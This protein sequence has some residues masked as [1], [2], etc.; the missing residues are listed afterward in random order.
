[1][2]IRTPRGVGAISN[3][4]LDAGEILLER[5]LTFRVV[6]DHGV[7]GGVRRLDVEVVTADE[8][9]A[10]R[11]AAKA[12]AA[13]IAQV[14]GT[15]RLLAD[16]DQL[17]A[18]K[19][20]RAALRQALDPALI[21]AE[22]L[23][24][25]ADRAI[26]DS[27]RTALDTGDPAKLRAALTRAGTKAKIKPIGK[28]GAKTT[29][30]PATMEAVGD[31]DIPAGAKVIIERRGTTLVGL[32][33]PLQRAKV[34]LDVPPAKAAGAASAGR[35]AAPTLPSLERQ[36]A[37]EGVSKA[38]LA[39]VRRMMRTAEKTPIVLRETDLEH[40]RLARSHADSEKVKEFARA[41]LGIYNRIAQERS[42]AEQ[43]SQAIAPKLAIPQGLTR[44]DLQRQAAE[45]L[46]AAIKDKPVIIR[47]AREDRL[48]Q[49]L[50][51]GRFKTQFETSTSSGYL[52]TEIRANFE[53]MTWGYPIDLPPAQRPVYGY[54]SLHGVTK[55]SQDQAVAAYGNIQIV[56]RDTVRPRITVSASD[57]LAYR[58]E[59]RPSPIEHIDYRSTRG[60]DADYTSPDAAVRYDYVEAQIHGGVTWDDVAEVVFARQPEQATIE[61]LAQ[62]GVSWRVL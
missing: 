52:N 49:A 27:L 22:Q 30:D 56:L 61:A 47:R 24:A 28:A 53:D 2:T 4:E 5:G 17:I 13:E 3:S 10:T 42:I 39:E 45:K 48:R 41:H 34:R 26:L 25:G 43:W 20:D 51:D 16:L 46:S 15:A 37:A 33:D 44:A 59:L 11:A 1:L 9:K 50:A 60:H 21:E 38:E 55:A 7:V 57:S 18:R 31:V 32:T 23:Y 12:R 36:A 62:R 8:R 54:V 19:A 40:A 29:F 58:R 14:Q 6:T 35:A